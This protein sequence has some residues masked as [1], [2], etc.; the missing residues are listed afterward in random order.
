M[1]GLPELLTAPW[2]LTGRHEEV[3]G[4]CSAIEDGCPAFFVLGEA[5]TGK[6][7]LAREVLRRLERDGW[8]TA[9]ATATESAQA[10]PW[11][12]W[13]TSSVDAVG[14]PTLVQATARPSRTHRGRPLVLHLDDAHHLDASSATLLVAWWRPGWSAW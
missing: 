6:T 1:G 13:P 9:G 14:H 11:V 5:G 12:R 2:P 4:V 10:T 8:V 3:D 7:R